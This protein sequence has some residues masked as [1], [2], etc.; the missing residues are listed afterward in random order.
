MGANS[1]LQ[2]VWSVVSEFSWMFSLSASSLVW[3][4]YPCFLCMGI[5]FPKICVLVYILANVRESSNYDSRLAVVGRV[6]TSFLHVAMLL[7]GE[8]RHYDAYRL[9]HSSLLSPPN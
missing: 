8:L 2:F 4:I 9:R 3:V 1:S 7:H 6:H 5:R